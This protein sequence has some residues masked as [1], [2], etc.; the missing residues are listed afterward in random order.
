MRARDIM[1]THVVTVRPDAA[2][3]DAATVLT[4]RGFT[5]LPVIDDQGELVG[6]VTEADIINRRFTGTQQ[7][8]QPHTASET[9]ADLMIT[10]VI[11]VSQD[12]DITVVVNEMLTN[13]RR[14]IPVMDGTAL[15]GVITRRD[16][17]RVLARTDEEIATDVR[18]HLTYLGGSSRW[19]V[20]VVNGEASLGDKFQNASDRFVAVALAEAVPGVIR[21]VAVSR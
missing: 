16:V 15:V 19:M 6:I 13:K 18:K 17:V 20:Q 10:P 8:G 3:V 9:V 5:A 7:P 2:V 11:G 14:C 21:A 1:T 12:A 4:G